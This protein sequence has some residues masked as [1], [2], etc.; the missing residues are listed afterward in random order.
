M[1]QEGVAVAANDQVQAGD[2]L[3][4]IHVRG[5]AV[6]RAG[7]HSQAAGTGCNQRLH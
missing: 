6:A 1:P 3:G 2:K 7:V 4:G 5:V